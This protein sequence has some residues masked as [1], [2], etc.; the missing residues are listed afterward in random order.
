MSFSEQLNEFLFTIS[1]PIVRL[2]KP[3]I[4]ILM[5]IVVGILI[6]DYYKYRK[7]AYYQVTKLPYI[8]VRNDTGRYGEYL[9]YKHLKDF[10]KIGAKFLF[11]VYIPK[12]DG[13]TTEIDVLMICSKGLFVFESKNYSGWIFGSKDQ[14]NWYQTLPTGRGKSHKEHFYNPI[15]QNRTHIK[16]LKAILG[17]QIPMRSIVVFSERCTL[18]SVEV[19]NC[20]TCVIKRGDI[21]AT[22]SEICKLT[23]DDSLSEND[24]ESV[25]K[26][27]YP[28]TQVDTLTKL[29]HI[30][31]IK[32][33]IDPQFS[34]TT[35]FV[36]PAAVQTVTESDSAD[37]SVTVEQTAEVIETVQ[38]ETNINEPIVS[39]TEQ[40]QLR[41]CPKCNGDLVLRKAT[42]G[43]NAGKQ[44]YGC[45]NYPKC[46]YILNIE[47][48]NENTARL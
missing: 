37:N 8:S 14:K 13:E 21:A 44:F 46:R 17:E 39:P 40:S 7:G 34:P 5:I 23:S 32:S 3:I 22:V 20:D 38:P 42:R 36:D 19:K 45:S 12:E 26:K 31:N 27:L 2:L 10:E 6:Y 30:E 35:I 1:Q 33:K 29:Q 25:Y 43:A 18:K 16:Y 24:I 28:Y 48:E 4:L 11:N 47:K 15:M 41:K 9:I